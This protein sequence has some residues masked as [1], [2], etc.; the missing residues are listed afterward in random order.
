MVI[1]VF[2]AFNIEVLGTVTVEL[3]DNLGVLIP[4]DKVI[5]HIKAFWRNDSFY[6]DMTYTGE[7]NSNEVD[8][9]TPTMI[10][11][12]I[13]QINQRQL[14][15]DCK[16]KQEIDVASRQKLVQIAVDFLI[17][18][19]GIGVNTFIRQLMAN[20]LVKLFP[21][22][23]IQNGSQFGTVSFHNVIWFS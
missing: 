1:P 14:L 7:A 17:V 12:Y 13:K 2:D 18:N 16:G 15:I 19:Y 20:A 4:K 21:S 22:L 3:R 11:T 5:Q 6:F 10:E 23:E 8:A 9:I